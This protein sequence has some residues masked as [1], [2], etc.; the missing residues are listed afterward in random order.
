MVALTQL[1]FAG[2][3]QMDSR[4]AKSAEEAKPIKV[5]AKL[6]NPTLLTLDN[7]KESLK[8]VLGGKPSII[9]FYRG[10]WC[11][12][13]NGQLSDI[14]R[15]QA[16]FAKK[17]YQIVAISPDTPTELKKTL[18]KNELTYKLVSDFSAE[19]MKEFGV[20]WRAPDEMVKL[21]KEKY[22]T[23]LEKYSGN[24]Q[25]VLPVPSVYVV[26]AKGAIT[27]AYSNPDY[28]VRLKGKDIL[29]VI[30]EN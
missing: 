20:A 17:G 4:V 29:K 18:D 25:H 12:F 24:N 23:D 10:G 7:K 21:Y 19:A 1:G 26:N 3:G 8:T 2:V 11:P 6:P 5:G 9:I 15:M 14:G 13:C 16:D 27:Y 22:N 28:R 30:S